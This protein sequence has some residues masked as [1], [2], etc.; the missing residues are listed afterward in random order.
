MR[1][2]GTHEWQKWVDE[3]R[4]YIGHELYDSL[5]TP[6]LPDAVVNIEDWKL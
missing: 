3:A 5:L 1:A 6:A 4:E 2:L